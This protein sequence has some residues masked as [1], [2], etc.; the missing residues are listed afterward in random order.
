MDQVDWGDPESIKRLV[1]SMSPGVA[2]E[3]PEGVRA[4]SKKLASTV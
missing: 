1:A 2:L 3:T 4:R